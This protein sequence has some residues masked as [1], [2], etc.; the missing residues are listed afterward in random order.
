MA[1]KLKPLPET[2]PLSSCRSSADRLQALLGQMLW[3]SSRPGRCL[4]RKVMY[5]GDLFHLLI[6]CL[7][8]RLGSSLLMF[9][10]L[11]H[12]AAENPGR[13]RPSPAGVPGELP[14]G[15]GSSAS[16]GERRVPRELF[17]ARNHRHL[18]RA[19]LPSRLRRC[20]GGMVQV[21]RSQFSA[22]LNLHKASEENPFSSTAALVRRALE[23]TGKAQHFSHTS[24][25]GFIS[26]YVNFR[27]STSG[28]TAS[29]GMP[30]RRVPNSHVGGW[31]RCEVPTG[32]LAEQ[33]SDGRWAPPPHPWGAP[34]WFRGASLPPHPSTGANGSLSQL[35]M[36]PWRAE[37]KRCSLAC[38]GKEQPPSRIGGASWEGAAPGVMGKPQTKEGIMPKMSC[39]WQE[40]LG[41]RKAEAGASKAGGFAPKD[42]PASAADGHLP[43]GAA[44]PLL[45]QLLPA[46]IEPVST[47]ATC[48]WE[49][50][51]GVTAGMGGLGVFCMF[52][53]LQMC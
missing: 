22:G 23:T 48:V 5:L 13:P 16:P 33:V 8:T 17:P 1:E 47:A 41:I 34:A 15:S 2:Q 12:S 6:G 32:S 52:F 3:S 27:L 40:P 37:G 19:S 45:C 50:L 18:E 9:A 28:G 46:C 39:R 26:F 43:G 36:P 35:S 29:A 4:N 38:A 20:A 14:F 53:G 10:L 7:F 31:L 21:A 30:R 24:F 49:E 42:L 44:C 11:A 51:M 25:L